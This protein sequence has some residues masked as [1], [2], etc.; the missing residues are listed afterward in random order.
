MMESSPDNGVWGSK[1]VG[2]ISD[3]IQRAY[4]D[5]LSTDTWVQV[6]DMVREI[7]PWD[8][9]AV[10]FANVQTGRL[11]NRILC[12]VSPELRQCVDDYL[13]E[14]TSIAEAADA[15]GLT[16]WRPSEAIGEQEY[17]ESEIR[18]HLSRDFQLDEQI[19]MVCGSP[20]NIT[21]R[22]WFLRET[23]KPDF[24]VRDRRVLELLQPHLCRALDIA[25]VLLEGEPYRHAFEDAFRPVFICDSTG[26]IMHC[27]KR[28]K[29]FAKVGGGDGEDRLAEIE[30]LVQRMISQQTD[31]ALAEL[32]GQKCQVYL[33]TV[34]TP[35]SPTTYIFFITSA[36]QVRETL[37]SF[38]RDHGFSQREIEICTMA[39]Q[40]MRNREI[41]EKLFI[42]ESTV[43]DHVTSIFEKLGIDSRGG[44]VSKLLG[45]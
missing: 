29:L 45:L 13:S 6:L 24:D 36:K 32:A 37:V 44:I 22:F 17:E 9:S 3:I 10:A 39:A 26:K 12:N 38:M 42:A 33:S 19:C 15:R 34:V 41:A 4:T 16:I 5:T 30:A 28:G 11:D 43:K 27:S 14:I 40:G 2:I 25:K 35:H 18:Q 7:M 20:P 8:V 31:Y 1:E 23:A 21:A